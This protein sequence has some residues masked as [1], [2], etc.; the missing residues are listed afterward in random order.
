MGIGPWPDVTIAEAREHAAN[1]R[2]SARF[3]VDP[4]E[5]RR[6]KRERLHRITVAEAVQG[7]FEA[8]QAELKGDGIAGRWMS[9]LSLHVLLK[10]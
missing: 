6:K 3:G 5:E 10:I 9:P 8:R 1:A 2:R 7:C 4:I